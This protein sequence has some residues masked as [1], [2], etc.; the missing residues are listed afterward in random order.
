VTF[1]LETLEWVNSD[2]VAETFESEKP[3]WVD[4]DLGTAANRTVAQW[5]MTRSPF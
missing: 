3:E 5:Y 1:E 2:F 4:S